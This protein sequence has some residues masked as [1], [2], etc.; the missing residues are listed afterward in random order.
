MRAARKRSAEEV[1]TLLDAAIRVLGRKAAT[2][3]V[4]DV[5]TEAHLSTRAF[6]RHFQSRDELLLAVYERD[7]DA[8][9]ERL[10]ARIER[11]PSKRVGLIAW[12]DE[13]LLLAYAPR[14][15]ARTRVL[16]MEAKRL[17]ARYPDELGAIRAAQLAPLV[18]L[19][20]AGRDDG[21]FPLAQPETDAPLIH[22]VVWALAEGR[23][24][25]RVSMPAAD[26]R[27][28]VLRFVLPALGAVP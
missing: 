2:L 1:E 26:A 24:L 14:R 7:S 13:T 16:T 20:D 19:L 22:A 9:V 18:E 10:R 15:A 25:N 12:I 4:A 28:H 11:W 5:L 27:S 23:L 3:T 17:E 21:S 6:Y 8:G